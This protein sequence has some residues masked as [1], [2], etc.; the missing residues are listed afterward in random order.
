MAR[1]TDGEKIDKLMT[2]VAT[3]TKR[4]NRHGYPSLRDRLLWRDLRNR[5]LWWDLRD[6]FLWRCLWDRFLWHL[7]IPSRETEQGNIFP[8]SRIVYRRW[9]ERERGHRSGPPFVRAQS[10]ACPLTGT[11]RRKSVDND[12]LV[13][14]SQEIMKV[15]G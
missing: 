15:L 9:Q 11:I 8:F 14:E 12:A 10:A 2:V 6:W 1:K 4:L 13:T 3:L 5:P 7:E